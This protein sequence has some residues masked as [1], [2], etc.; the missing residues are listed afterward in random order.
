MKSNKWR[1]LFC[2]FFFLSFGLVGMASN[3]KAVLAACGEMLLVPVEQV[4]GDY[5]VDVF[6][7]CFPEI[8][9]AWTTN[10]PFGDPFE[11]VYDFTIGTD[12]LALVTMYY[13]CGGFIPRQY[14]R[15]YTC[16]TL[17]K[18]LMTCIYD[19]TVGPLPLG[20]YLLINFY[21]PVEFKAGIY[22]WATKVGDVI[23]GYPNVN[24]VPPEC[25]T[26]HE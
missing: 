7:T 3:S 21:D 6:G 8:K 23:Y 26:L 20:T 16:N 12:T 18:V 24:T 10:D 15:G 25:F 17:E 4:D 2:L 11:K 9:D 13:H 1:I 19:W 22:D 14:A 5:Q